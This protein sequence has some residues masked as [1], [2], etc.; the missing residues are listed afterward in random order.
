MANG[1]PSL[2]AASRPRSLRHQQANPIAPGRSEAL[3]F[4]AT[5][6][7][8]M[9]AKAASVIYWSTAPWKAHS[10]RKRGSKEDEMKYHR[11]SIAILVVLL[12][13]GFARAQVASSA[14]V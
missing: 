8:P 2:H 1:A 7:S 9:A 11:V 10:R 12:G 3:Q 14:A 6:P 4:D 13:T 5:A